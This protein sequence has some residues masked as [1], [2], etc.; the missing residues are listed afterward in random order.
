MACTQRTSSS[1][2]DVVDNSSEIQLEAMLRLMYIST[3]ICWH[4]HFQAS[5]YHNTY[6]SLQTLCWYLQRQQGWICAVSEFRGAHS[7]TYHVISPM[8]TA[9]NSSPPCWC[10]VQQEQEEREGGFTGDLVPLEIIL[11]NSALLECLSCHVK[12]RWLWGWSLSQSLSY[13]VGV[14]LRNRIT[15]S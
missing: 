7:H 2:K 10:G 4:V 8:T 12:R 9:D 3:L 1:D 5:Q 14:E 6:F 13:S 11:L 15:F